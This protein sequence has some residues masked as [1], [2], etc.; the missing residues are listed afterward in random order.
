MYEIF[1]ILI[2]KQIAIK[3]NEITS[4]IYYGNSIAKCFA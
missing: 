2:Y 4:S 1:I 3:R